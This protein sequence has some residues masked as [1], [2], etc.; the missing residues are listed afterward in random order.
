[1]ANHRSRGRIHIFPRLD[2]TL[3]KTRIPGKMVAH[4]HRSLRLHLPLHHGHHLRDHRSLQRLNRH[5]NVHLH[6]LH[7]T[8]HIFLLN[9]NFISHIQ[10]EQ[11]LILRLG[12]SHDL[13]VEMS[14]ALEMARVVLTRLV[15]SDKFLGDTVF[16][17]ECVFV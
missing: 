1:M 11:F 4:H 15:F 2:L 12:M 9:C 16:V 5:Q 10:S 7:R 13:C 6:L 3:A 8:P 17:L 14:S